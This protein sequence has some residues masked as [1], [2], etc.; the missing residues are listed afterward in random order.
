MSYYAARAL[1]VQLVFFE[2][3]SKSEI[4][5]PIVLSRH[6]D[7][8]GQHMIRHNPLL[9]NKQQNLVGSDKTAWGGSTTPLLSN[10]F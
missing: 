1:G 6:C 7:L 3:G 8:S 2:I 4:Y 9:R 5:K 10:R